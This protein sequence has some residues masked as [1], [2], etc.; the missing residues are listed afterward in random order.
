MLKQQLEKAGFKVKLEVREYSRLESD[1][2]AGK[3]DA[4]VS[5]RNTMLDTGDPVS[6]LASDYTCDGSYNLALL[7]DKKVD[8]A[9]AAAEDD[10]PTPPSGRTRRWPRR[11]RSSAPTPSS[12]WSTSASSPASAARRA[13]V[14]SS[15]R[16]SAP[17]SA[18]APGADGRRGRDCRTAAQAARCGVRCSPAALLC[19]S[20]LLP[21]LSRTDPALTVLKA[22]SAERDPT[23][24]VL[25]AIR[26]QLGLDAGPLHLLG[27]LARRAAAR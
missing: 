25:A 27:Q 5:A 11:R 26:A 7:C 15:T 12:R 13:A 23:P 10:Q 17:S 20:A 2:L 3:F 18:S 1:A 9:V 22:R 8:Q 14:C 6:V 4:F 16:T 21:W 24:E 19:G